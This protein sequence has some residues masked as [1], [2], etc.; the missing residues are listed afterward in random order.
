MKYFTPLVLIFLTACGGKKEDAETAKASAATA[1]GAPIVEVVHPQKKAFSSDVTIT[2]NLEA[3]RM[4]SLHAMEGGF[5][6]S[7]S[8]DIGD[9][10]AAG[11]TIAELGNPE[12]VYQQ[13]QAEAAWQQAKQAAV[14][15][16]AASTKAAADLAF[17]K[18][19]FDRLSGIYSHTP[20]LVTADD[21]DR[22]EAEFLAAKAALDE[23]AA[24]D[25]LAAAAVES[26]AALNNALKA[27]AGMLRIAAPFS[28]YITKRYVDKGALVANALGN[29]N[30]SPVVD[31]ADVSKLRLVVEYPES[32]LAYIGKG[33]KVEVTFPALASRAFQGEISRVSAALNAQSKTVRAE[34]DLPADA[35]LKP[36]MYAK[37]QT[38][39]QSSHDALAVPT[40]AITAVK[41]QTFIF[42]VHDNVVKKIPVELGM[43]DKF[44]IEIKSSELT[45]NDWVV[46]Q[47]KGLINEGME[48]VAKEKD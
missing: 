7:I 12:L 24:G 38:R 32:D 47:G 31:M 26:A 22:A 15:A 16:K 4:V 46:I 10:V 36:G 1:A 39:Q 3:N 11:Q 6:K 35:K 25:Q 17:K 40:Q 44:F 18:K 33:T 34:I 13:K 19:R 8:K 9:Y 45:E 28:G 23:A 41:N 20:D 29:S 37:V 2:G 27:R 43:E 42:T 14:S 5:V 48:V 30:A 21:L